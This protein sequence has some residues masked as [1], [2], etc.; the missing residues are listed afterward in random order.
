MLDLARYYLF[1]GGMGTMLQERGLQADIQVDG[2]VT[3]KNVRQFLDAGANILVS[4]SAVFAGDAT[5]N[6]RAFMNILKEYEAKEK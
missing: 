2:G 6:T 3:L 4:G 1:D 5:E